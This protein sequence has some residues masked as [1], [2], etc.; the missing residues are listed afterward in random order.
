MADVACIVDQVYRKLCKG[1]QRVEMKWWFTNPKYQS[2]LRRSY[3]P[4]HSGHCW[5]HNLTWLLSPTRVI[6]R[7]DAFW[8]ETMRPSKE[9]VGIFVTIANNSQS[10]IIHNEKI[11]H[12]CRYFCRTVPIVP[13]RCM[14]YKIYGLQSAEMEPESGR[15]DMEACTME[16]VPE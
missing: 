8:C 11:V 14:T 10:T 3:Y 9:G 2:K 15:C 7:L 1:E 16:T 6:R 12:F 13:K 5:D 4:L